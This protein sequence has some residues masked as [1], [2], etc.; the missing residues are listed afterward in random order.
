[1][2]KPPKV[3][4][5]DDEADIAEMVCDVLEEDGFDLVCMTSGDEA[6]QRIGEE[7]KFDVVITD[8]NLG[9]EVDGIDIARRARE[10]KPDATIIYTSGA[11][12]KRVAYEGIRGAAFIPKPF[13]ASEISNALIWMLNEPAAKAA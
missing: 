10:V 12:A 1:M 4:V 3:L 2:R 8:I 5:L 6:L 11:A 9:G 13:T 7:D